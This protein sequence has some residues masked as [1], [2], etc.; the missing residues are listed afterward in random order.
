M[1]MSFQLPVFIDALGCYDDDSGDRRGALL[2]TLF[3]HFAVTAWSRVGVPCA[4]FNPF[5]LIFSKSIIK[6]GIDVRTRS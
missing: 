1:D 4:N 3:A 2:R 6:L 5:I